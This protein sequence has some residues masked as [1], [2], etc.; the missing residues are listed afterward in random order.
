MCLVTGLWKGL[1]TKGFKEVVFVKRAVFHLDEI[2]M[3]GNFTSSPVLVASAL[4]PGVR[5]CIGFL[6]PRIRCWV[7]SSK[8]PPGSAHLSL[9]VVFPL[10]HNILAGGLLVCQPNSK[11]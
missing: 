5:D 6:V 11:L 10:T 7:P 9:G 1:D 2:P 8:L 3:Q 4:G